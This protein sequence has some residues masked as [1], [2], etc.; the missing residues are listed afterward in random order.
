MDPQEEPEAETQGDRPLEEPPA[1]GDGQVPPEQ[2]VE[3][4]KLVN[5]AVNAASSSLPTA[6]GSS[7]STD[8][9]EVAEFARA[10]EAARLGGEV[11]VEFPTK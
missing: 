1:G 9:V 2:Q 10:L 7:A 5:F 8:D 6:A 11:G 4:T 3:T